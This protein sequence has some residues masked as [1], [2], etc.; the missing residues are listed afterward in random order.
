MST[1]VSSALLERLRSK[2]RRLPLEDYQC[3]R[4]R[5]A[6]WARRN[7]LARGEAVPL[8]ADCADS[9]YNIGVVQGIAEELRRF[10]DRLDPPARRRSG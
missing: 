7:I 8:T 4:T 6:S 5:G 2:A 9:P 1:T 3:G 10:A